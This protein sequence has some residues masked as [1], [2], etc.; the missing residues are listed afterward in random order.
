MDA[1]KSR[2][3]HWQPLPKTTTHAHY[4]DGRT[5]PT[6]IPTS[7]IHL[8]VLPSGQC[9]PTYPLYACTHPTCPLSLRSPRASITH[10]FSIPPLL[11]AHPIPSHP[12]PAP[13]H[14]VLHGFWSRALHCTA[15]RRTAS[16]H[17][18][19]HCTTPQCPA[20]HRASPHLTLPLTSVRC[21][22]TAPHLTPHLTFTPPPPHLLH[23]GADLVGGVKKGESGCHPRPL[24]EDQ[25]V[26]D[27]LQRTRITVYG[28]QPD[29]ELNA[30]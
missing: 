4:L 1:H 24:L 14:T 26:A 5:V 17:N 7:L 29:T 20:P 10:Q 21:P 27:N 12:I 30:V 25:S 22:H 13:Y 15:P 19:P 16:H 18:A 2:A 6:H 3:P 28:V 23:I 8:P 11:L 9:P